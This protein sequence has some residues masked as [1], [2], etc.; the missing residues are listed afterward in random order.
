VREALARRA[1]RMRGELNEDGREL[2]NLGKRR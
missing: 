2:T 1:L